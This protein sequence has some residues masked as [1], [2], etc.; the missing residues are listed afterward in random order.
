[1]KQPGPFVRAASCFTHEDA[2]EFER[3]GRSWRDLCTPS[4][5]WFGNSLARSNTGLQSM[6]TAWSLLSSLEG[7][8][9]KYV[10]RDLGVSPL[11]VEA[12]RPLVVR[13]G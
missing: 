7:A 11:H 8:A 12:P 13:G 1:M 3:A 10:D 6:L 4:R 9:T 5:R 2:D